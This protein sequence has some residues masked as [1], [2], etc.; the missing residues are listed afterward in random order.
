MAGWNFNYSLQD[1]KVR[2]ARFPLFGLGE[3]ISQIF[4]LF[5]LKAKVTGFTGLLIGCE[6]KSKPFS[7]LMSRRPEDMGMGD[8]QGKRFKPQTF[9]MLANWTPI[10]NKF[11]YKKIPQTF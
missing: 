2:M 4:S 11:T 3:V 7:I 1:F 6:L 8:K 5:H 10:K 9:Y